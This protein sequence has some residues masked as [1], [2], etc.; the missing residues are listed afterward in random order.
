MK[1][2]YLVKYNRSVPVCDWLL[3]KAAPVNHNTV[4]IVMEVS[5]DYSEAG[6]AWVRWHGNWDWDLC[7]P[8][9][10]EV[11]SSC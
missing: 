4:G 8:E 5:E 2:G 7:Y 10:L 3:D 1:A 6:T 9:D 11:I